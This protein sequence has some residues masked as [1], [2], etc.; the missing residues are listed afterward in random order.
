MLP[1]FQ[2]VTPTMKLCTFKKSYQLAYE[3]VSSVI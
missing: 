2:I 1:E 3:T